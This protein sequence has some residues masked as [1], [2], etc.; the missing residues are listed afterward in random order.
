[1]QVDLLGPAGRLEALYEAPAAPRFAAV[2]CHPHPRHGG[3]LH[4]HA[5]YRLA[6]AVREQGGATLR[7]N[8]RG[9]GRSAGQYDQGR[10]E[11]DD[12]RAA[13]AWLAAE[14]PGLPRWA[15]GFSFG[16]WMALEAGCAVPAVPGVLCLGLALSLR[17]G[18]AERARGCAKPVAVVQAE[19]DE[20]ALP[21]EVERALE[22]A[23]APRR[24]TVVEG[25]THLF[26]EALPALERAAGEAMAWLLEAAP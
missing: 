6:R 17:E 2:V 26:T 10:G 14:H 16:A 13:L 18:V 3:T 25:A 24:L 8:F 23:A 5:T 1:M 12:V 22:G 11:A 15:A 21:A 7:F 20:F 4:N 9:V 19:R